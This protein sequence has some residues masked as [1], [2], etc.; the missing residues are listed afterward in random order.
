MLRIAAQ[1]VS[2]QLLS[3]ILHAHSEREAPKIVCDFGVVGQQFKGRLVGP[4]R[5]GEVA[6]HLERHAKQIPAEAAVLVLGQA[7]ER[8]FLPLGD[9][10]RV[11][12]ADSLHE[13]GTR[14]VLAVVVEGRLDLPEG[15]RRSGASSDPAD[16]L[17]GG[18][19]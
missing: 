11:D 4:Q 8:E 9:V 10:P 15:L 5:I 12:R 1:K 3:V 6:P 17:T 19:P 2:E 18:E 16:E 14:C 13:R 7:L